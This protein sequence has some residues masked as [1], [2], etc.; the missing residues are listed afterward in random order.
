MFFKSPRS[1]IMSVLVLGIASGQY[2]L[3]GQLLETFD[4]KQG[5]YE[6]THLLILH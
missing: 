6:N 1:V 5:H 4:T 2:R 3:R